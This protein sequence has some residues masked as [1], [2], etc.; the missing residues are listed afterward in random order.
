M[1]LQNPQD[2]DN[3][4]KESSPSPTNLEIIQE[5]MHDPSIIHNFEFDCERCDRSQN[6]NLNHVW[7]PSSLLNIPWSFHPFS[8]NKDKE[9]NE[10]QGSESSKTY[11]QQ[12]LP[13]W[14]LNTLRVVQNKRFAD[15]QLLEGKRFASAITTTTVPNVRNSYISKA[16]Y[17][18]DEALKADPTHIETMLAYGELCCM[19]FSSPERKK[20]GTDMWNWVLNIDPENKIVIDLIERFNAREKKILMMRRNGGNGNATN[21]LAG[22]KR[23]LTFNLDRHTRDVLAERAL[24]MGDTI[25]VDEIHALGTDTHSIDKKREQYPLIPDTDEED[26][27]RNHHRLKSKKHRRK[28]K[29]SRKHHRKRRHYSDSEASSSSE[30]ESTDDSTVSNISDRKKR[31]KRRSSSHRDESSRRHRKLKRKRKNESRR[32][33]RSHRHHR[34]RRRSRHDSDKDDSDANISAGE[35]DVESDKDELVRDSSRKG[36]NYQR[37]E[38]KRSNS[39]SPSPRDSSDSNKR[40]CKNNENDEVADQEDTKI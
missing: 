33:S 4:V 7:T 21:T 35:S 32:R 9:N 20:K 30:D 13:D 25:D 1:S 3:D 2:I 23:N 12:N 14:D 10:T 15:T 28:S 27:K 34:L 31:R 5:G 8:Q 19:E 37:K 18:Y 17:Y 11:R 24:A 36:K 6:P 16:E 26:N 38:K 39:S 40:I 22:G 29:S